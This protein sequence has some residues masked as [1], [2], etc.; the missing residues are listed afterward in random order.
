VRELAGVLAARGHA[1][2]IVAPAR[3]AHREPGV[4]FVG[5]VVDVPWAGSIA[6]LCPSHRSFRR[7]QRVV[8]T[9]RPDVVH[10][11][12]PFVPSTSLLTVLAADAP[13]VATFHAFT[14]RSGITRTTAPLL[15]VL[16]RR[17]AASMA[18]STAAAQHAGHGMREPLVVVPNGVRIDRFRRPAAGRVAR[19]GRVVLWVHRLEPR[20]GFRVALDAFARLAA[21]VDDVSLVVVGSGPDRAALAALPAPLRARV[22]MLGNV[23]DDDLPRYHAAADVFIASATGKESFGLALAEAMAAGLPIVASDIRGYREV[24][25]DGVEAVLVPPRDASALAVGLRRV[26][27]DP[28]L[29]ATLARG[30]RARA[31]QYSWDVVVPEIEAI[32]LSARRRNASQATTTRVASIAAS[33][34]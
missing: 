23:G 32:Y 7:I 22:R 31:E 5:R 26:L 24:V 12:E 10:V 21:D 6:T 1:V 11:H 17:I 28:G 2:A 18:V 4:H 25:R 34:P 29:A 20:K 9:F 15:R 13:V 3:V 8:A 30:G 33:S 27:T 14:E 16:G 19:S